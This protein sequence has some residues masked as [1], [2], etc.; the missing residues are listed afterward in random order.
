MGSLAPARQA[1]RMTDETRNENTSDQPDDQRT[2]PTERLPGEDDAPA[3]G[4]APA[5]DDTAAAGA[6]PAADDTAA[7]GDTPPAGDAP[8]AG[9]PRKLTRSGAD[10]VIGGVASGLGRYFNLDPLLFR[11]A[12][13]VLSFAGGFGVLAYL[14]LLAFVPTDGAEKPGGT[15]K[16]AAVAGA[17][18]LGVALVAF[19]GTPFFFFGPALLILAV[20]GLAGF[21]LWRGFGGDASDDP[22]RTI[23]RIFLAAL[24][25]FA[26]AGAALGVGIAT[27][28]G[29]GVVIA[30]LAVV[31][32]FVLI[33]TAFVGGARWLIVP[34]LALVL[35]LGV[36]A[37]A[38]VDLDGGIGER[39]YHP[40]SVAQLRDEYEIGIGAI[41]LDL[42]DLDLPTG[43]TNVDIDVGL[44]EAVIYVPRGACVT[45]DIDIG[46]GEADVF[47]RNNDGFDVSFDEAATP[48]AGR[49]QL[50]IH[51]DAVAG[52]IEVVREGAEPDFGEG[53]DRFFDRAD[54]VVFEGGTGC[55]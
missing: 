51:A 48:P 25:A 22:A 36:V 5:A 55:A 31:T 53:R 46:A 19:L 10:A 50:H 4:A 9:E 16:A 24:L 2:G 17:V 11:I 13:V 6:A 33:A 54:D 15:S 18:V 40:T 23:G 47:D 42:T 38:D 7:A 12:F 35:P 52:A 14:L 49:P 29:G 32:G 8:P 34:A 21:L 27:A 43:R 20:V 1:C 44:G 30:S 37:A 45:S 26:V 41:D 39:D 3:A 28:L